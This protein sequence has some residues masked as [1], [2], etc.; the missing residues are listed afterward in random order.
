MDKEYLSGVELLR[1]SIANEKQFPCTFQP[2]Y[3]RSQRKRTEIKLR[4]CVTKQDYW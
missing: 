2:D 4:K 1:C 3:T